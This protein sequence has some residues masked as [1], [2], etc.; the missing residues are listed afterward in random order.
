MQPSSA[1]WSREAGPLAFAHR[2]GAK[3]APENT[4]TAFERAV[5][6]G[7]TWIETDVH[8]TSDGVG[9]LIH[10]P[11]LRRVANL[12]L[13]VAAHPWAVVGTSQ[14]ADGRPPA[15]LE[16]VLAAWPDVNWNIDLKADSSVDA[17]VAALERC[18][19]A[20]RVIVGSFSGGRTARA[21]AKLGGRV[22]T[23][24]GRNEIAMFALA[25][26]AQAVRRLKPLGIPHLTKT[27][28]LQVP[29]RFRRRYLV[30]GPFVDLAHAAGKAVHVWTI[31]DPSEMAYLL[32]L[33][34]DGIMTDRPS[35]LRDV[36]SA[37]GQWR[38]A[39]AS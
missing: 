25:S 30:D 16:E 28:A 36:L 27:A 20:D 34:V 14:L 38:P 39:S 33:G 24:A 15:R 31:D 6:L 37:R 29:L 32:D 7:F 18:R 17:V 22:A 13:T 5:S 21:R 10:D 35:D 4:W 11:D 19:A 3:E 12:D 8:A 23:S 26:R 9:V 2:G 1:L